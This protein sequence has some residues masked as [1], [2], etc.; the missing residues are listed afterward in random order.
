[1]IMEMFK[2]IKELLKRIRWKWHHDLAACMEEGEAVQIQKMQE[3]FKQL[4]SRVDLL[5][6]IQEQ[7]KKLDQ[8]IDRTG[9]LVQSQ[10]VFD[11]DGYAR[12][13]EIERVFRLLQDRESQ[14]IFW[15]RL[16]HSKSRDLAPLFRHL[17]RSERTG[18][19]RDLFSLMDSLMSGRAS[20]E[21][22]ILYGTTPHAKKL[23]LTMRE[24][25]CKVDCVCKE[26]DARPF[27]HPSVSPLKNDDWLGLPVI[28][29]EELLS[30][31][32][33]AQIVIGDVYC[34]VAEDYLLR[35]GIKADHIWLRFSLWGIQ[36]LEPD[37]MRPHKHEVYIDGGSYDLKNTLEFI[38]WCGGDHDAAYAFEADADNYEK[39]LKK[40]QTHPILSDGR[41][42]LFNAALWKKDEVLHF[43]DGHDESSS[44]MADG[45]TTV[46]ARTID[47]V[48]QGARVTFIKLDIEGAEMEALIGAQESI[49]KWKPRLAICIYHKPEDIIELPLYIHGL[50][51]EYK[52]FIRHYS[53][54]DS[55]TVLY[56]VCDGDLSFS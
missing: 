11:L 35:K 18:N 40:I 27:T 45:N 33:D 12:R 30:K 50:V 39:C 41:V 25:G 28:T 29:E 22:I 3:R 20:G 31:H 37:I 52:M 8:Q 56:C 6:G 16:H 32:R 19:P 44:V 46:H 26:D 48:L 53:T 14:K 17:I 7:L 21:E 47:S 2:A 5:N 23:L 1:M 54:C 13:L 34:W 24:L 10:G 9:K 36:Y 38:E 4:D 15:A 55:E 51:P 42:H 49:R 43:R